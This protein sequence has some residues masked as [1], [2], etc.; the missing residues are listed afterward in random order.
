MALIVSHVIEEVQEVGCTSTLTLCINDDS[1]LVVNQ[2]RNK[3]VWSTVMFDHHGCTVCKANPP[4]RKFFFIKHHKNMTQQRLA[5]FIEY[6][7]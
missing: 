2:S 1:L 7:V 3:G 4:V 5:D 6:S